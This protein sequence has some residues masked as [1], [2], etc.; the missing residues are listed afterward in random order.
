MSLGE[1]NYKQLVSIG[2]II[3]KCSQYAFAMIAIISNKINKGGGFVFG[4][5]SPNWALLIFFFFFQ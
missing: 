5:F 1:I 2:K 4:F 3:L